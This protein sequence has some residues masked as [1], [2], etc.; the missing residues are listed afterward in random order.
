MHTVAKLQGNKNLDLTS[1]PTMRSNTTKR[2]SESKFNAR[3][4]R[5]QYL[6]STIGDFN[7]LIITQNLT[8]SLSVSL[9]ASREFS[10]FQLCS[11]FVKTEMQLVSSTLSKWL[12]KHADT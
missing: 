11:T 7:W 6:C 3:A 8:T 1:V 10:L 9:I 2:L 4:D 12:R 5:L